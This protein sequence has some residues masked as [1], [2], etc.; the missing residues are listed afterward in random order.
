MERVVYLLGAGFSAPLGLPVMSNFL[1]K[2]KDMYFDHSDRY[3]YFSDVFKLIRDFSVVK[4]YYKSD[5]FNIEEILSILEMSSQLEGTSLKK[6][7]N[8]IKYLSDV[9]KFYTPQIVPYQ[10]MLPSNWDRFIFGDNQMQNYF[11]NFYAS[12]H[13][14]CIKGE[15]FRSDEE[16]YRKFKAEKCTNVAATYAVLT[17]NYDRVLENFAD[18][19]LSNYFM[20]RD[21]LT[22]ISDFSDEIQPFSQ[23]PILAKLH[24]SV[25]LDNIVPPTWSKGVAREILRAWQMAYR[26]LV[27]A[28][29]IRIIGYSIPEADA[30]VKYLFK[31]AVMKAP[32]LKRLDI[33][34][35]DADGSVRQRYDAFVEFPRY[36]FKNK[37]VIDYLQFYTKYLKIHREDRYEILEFNKLENAHT[38]F[39]EQE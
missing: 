39:F 36:S 35:L 16:N 29:Q 8:L 22:F 32:H 38:S 10:Q 15:V 14:V 34:C 31:A 25:G 2:S 12:M 28:T 23:Q 37:D 27:E 33:L 9:V 6:K 24:G 11:G 21:R 3:N 1:E 7:R 20:E 13:N 17:L 30:Y 19:L 4:H 5:Q 18:H 26:V